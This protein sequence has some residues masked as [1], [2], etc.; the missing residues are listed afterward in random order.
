LSS[1]SSAGSLPVAS[2]PPEPPKRSASLGFL[3]GAG[4]LEGAGPVPIVVDGMAAAAAV[5]GEWMEEKARRM[6]HF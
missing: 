2:A 5:A 3:S 6:S 1:S 4:V